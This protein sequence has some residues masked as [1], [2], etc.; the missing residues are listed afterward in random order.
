MSAPAMA[1]RAPR[2]P[3]DRLPRGSVV[4]HS[5]AVVA[6]PR[7]DGMLL[8]D[9]DGGARMVIDQFGRRVWSA[10]AERPTLAVL[11]TQLR[12][13]DASV[14]RLAEDVTRLLARWR[15]RGVISWR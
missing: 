5:P 15:A 7:G 14:Q 4:A 2:A 8:L 9:M 1:T 3:H 6:C 10:L 13:D 12:V 11:L